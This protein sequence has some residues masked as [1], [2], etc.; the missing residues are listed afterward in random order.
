MRI[1]STVMR[2]A[3]A[4]LLGSTLLAHAQTNSDAVVDPVAAKQQAREIAQGDPS[5]WYREDATPQA[6]L[7]TLHKEIGAALQ[8]A[9]NACKRAPAAERN[10]CLSEARAVYTRDMAQAKAM[11]DGQ[12]QTP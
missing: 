10:A 3:C 11:V 1:S 2:G 12:G 7:K 6:K 4:F 9:R 8:E 5:R